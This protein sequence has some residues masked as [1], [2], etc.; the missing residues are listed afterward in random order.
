ME[1]LTKRLRASVLANPAVQL[2]ES[3]VW[4]LPVWTLDVVFNRV[5]RAKMDILMKMLLL[6]FEEAHIRRA[7]NLSEI[8]LVE[9]LFIEDLMKKMRRIGLIHL[10]KGIYRLTTKGKEQLKSG[11]IEEEMEEEFTEL[12]YSQS[13][14]EY[15]SEEIVAV[16]E[17][18]E[19]LTMYRYAKKDEEINTDRML[20]VLSNTKNELQENGFQT[21]VS[22]IS[23]F[24]QK[25]VERIPCYEF[26]LY[27]KEQDIFYV[28]VWN[29]LLEQW[30]DT[31]EKQIEEEEMAKWQGKWKQGEGS[32]ADT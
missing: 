14:D 11:I 26:Q 4:Y 30:D 17:I 32:G 22:E 15:W 12:F 3:A 9:E 18:N 10:D 5:R 28:R 7:A 23:G 2:K 1:K 29:T 8:L 21:V 20:E 27:N 6:A 16:P 31:L 24:D 19:K 25:T 13:H